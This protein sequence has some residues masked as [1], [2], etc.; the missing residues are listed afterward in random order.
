MAF[1]PTQLLVI[2]FADPDFRGE[3]A[4]ELERLTEHDTIRV[5]DVLLVTKGDDGSIT[6]VEIGEARAMGAVVRA[7]VGLEEDAAEAPAD[8]GPEHDVWYVADE[9][10]PGT[11]AAVAVIEHLWA[12][13]LRAAVERAGGVPLADAWL[14]PADLAG[15]EAHVDGGAPS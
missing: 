6:A 8:I 7:L 5:L 3:I 14:H 4:A 1:A 9:I 2:G 10:P 13:P 12:A 15:L 11:V